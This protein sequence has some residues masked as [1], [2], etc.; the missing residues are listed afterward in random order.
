MLTNTG[1]ECQPCIGLALTNTQPTY[2]AAVHW[3]S[4][5]IN[6]VSVN[7][8][9]AD[10]STNIQL[11]PHQHFVNWY[12]TDTHRLLPDISG[13]YRSMLS[14][15]MALHIK[16]VS[17]NI[18]AN[19]VTNTT[20]DKHG[21]FKNWK[22]FKFW[23]TSNFMSCFIHHTILY[24]VSTKKRAL[25]AL[26]STHIKSGVKMYC[27]NKSKKAENVTKIKSWWNCRP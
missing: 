18:L 4:M 1:L 17:V 26:S 12:S 5:N 20:Y 27:R 22:M 15:Y 9:W 23:E 16:R 25:K 21:L 11:I 14:L 10:K 19:S 3:V 24:K 13:V 2:W 6:Q 8:I 7:M